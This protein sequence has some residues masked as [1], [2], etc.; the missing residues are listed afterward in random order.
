[1]G[2]PRI[3]ELEMMLYIAGEPVTVPGCRYIVDFG[4]YAPGA[5]RTVNLWTPTPAV[6]Y[7]VQFDKLTWLDDDDADIRPG[8][9]GT[10]VT[11]SDNWGQVI[12]PWRPQLLYG[13]P[14]W[15]PCMMVWPDA[16]VGPVVLSARVPAIPGRKCNLHGQNASLRCQLDEWHPGVDHDF[17]MDPRLKGR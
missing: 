9:F 16:Y 6:E 7:R 2:S 12:A 10:A 8:W 4:E 5:F 15:H 11:V 13:R 1:M 3:P 14:W 17:Q